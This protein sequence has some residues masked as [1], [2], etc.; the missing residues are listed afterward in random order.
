MFCSKTIKSD[1]WSCVWLTSTST[2]YI[3][4]YIYIKR[5]ILMSL[6]IYIYLFIIIEDAMRLDTAAPHFGMCH[7]G[8]CA[9]LAVHG[10]LR[11]AK[12]RFMSWV[13]CLFC[14]GSWQFFACFDAFDLLWFPTLRFFGNLQNH[15]KL[16]LKEQLKSLQIMRHKTCG[17][18]KAAKI[19]K[20]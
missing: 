14:A 16:H 13:F 4:I 9:L 15:G 11:I 2:I 7:L 6:Y 12:L 20:N 17:S 5:F 10:F 1:N 19:I 3:Y 18:P 8:D